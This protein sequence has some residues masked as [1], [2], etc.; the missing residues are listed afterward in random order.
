MGVYVDEVVDY[1]DT[2]RGR[3]RRWGTRWSHLYADTVEELHFMADMLGL[4]R[5]Y[6]QD[7]KRGLPHTAHY[8]IIPR[9]R[10]RA[11]SLGAI[12]VGRL[13]WARRHRRSP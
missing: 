4:R 9:K 12:P 7:A 8:D 10:E 5:S 1:G 6:F 11:V 13:E 2:G 3:A